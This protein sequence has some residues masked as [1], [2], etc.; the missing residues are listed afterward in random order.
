ML[1]NHDWWFDGPRVRKALE[2][3]GIPVLE[4]RAIPLV[5]N[6]MPFWLAGVGDFGKRRMMFAARLPAWTRQ[7]R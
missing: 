1:G 2:A 7:V 6:R 5:F 4:D 3:E